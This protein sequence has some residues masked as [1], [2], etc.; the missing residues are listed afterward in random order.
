MQFDESVFE[1]EVGNL[2]KSDGSARFS[3]SRT[4]F[5]I[6]F[7]LFIDRVYLTVYNSK[8]DTIQLCSIFGPGEVRLMKEI[9]ERAYV[10]IVYKPRIGNNSKIKRF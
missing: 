4:V 7:F 5:W 10:N 6:I 2:T 9:A 3:I 8:D 1:A